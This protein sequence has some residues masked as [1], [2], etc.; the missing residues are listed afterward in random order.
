MEMKNSKTV[1]SSKP[2]F[3]IELKNHSWMLGFEHLNPISFTDYY[4]ELSYEHLEWF[5]FNDYTQQ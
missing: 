5:H 1:K 3:I 2:T 4:S